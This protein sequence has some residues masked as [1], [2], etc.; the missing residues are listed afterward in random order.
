MYY[1]WK[2]KITFPKFAAQC[3]GDHPVKLSSS[4]KS[5]FP[6]DNKADSF[7]KS[8]SRHAWCKG[9]LC[10]NS[11]SVDIDHEGDSLWCS[12]TS[13][14]TVVTQVMKRKL[15]VNIRLISPACRLSLLLFI[16][17]PGIDA[18]FERKR[19]D[20]KIYD[21]QSTERTVCHNF[22]VHVIITLY[23]LLLLILLITCTYVAL[24][25]TGKREGAT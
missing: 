19:P 14:A 25:L 10:W 3:K 17:H 1:K 15:H 13:A 4:Y 21:N 22:Y 9:K 20:V 11:S 5:T 6:L 23:V 8:P 24:F 16:E 18:F 12:I 7:S 2:S